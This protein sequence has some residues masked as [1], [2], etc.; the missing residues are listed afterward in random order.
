MIGDFG[1]S[2]VKKR[3]STV[4]STPSFISAHHSPADSCALG[5]GT[6]LFMAP[7]LL[8]LVR[9]DCRTQHG[10]KCGGVSVV[11][12]DDEGCHRVGIDEQIGF[13]AADMWALGLTLISLTIGRCPVSFGSQG[14]RALQQEA[15]P[16]CSFMSVSAALAQ[17]KSVALTT[18]ARRQHA[19]QHIENGVVLLVTC[20]PL[21]RRNGRVHMLFGK[22]PKR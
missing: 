15:P 20:S 5:V 11:I 17:F 13:A 14:F 19:R 22:S 18:S 9:D 7:E 16:R 21:T 10:E 8:A 6:P 3:L 4:T 1:I 2:V 12:A